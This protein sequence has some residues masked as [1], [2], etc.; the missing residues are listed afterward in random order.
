MRSDWRSSPTGFPFRVL[1]LNGTLSDAETFEAR[2]RVCDLG[3]L[4]SAFAKHPLLVTS[5]IK[6]KDDIMDS[7]REFLKGGR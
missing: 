5:E 6:N 1:Q 3:V 4:R 2:Q 7:I